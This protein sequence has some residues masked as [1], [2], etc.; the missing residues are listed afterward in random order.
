MKWMIDFKGRVIWFYGNS[1]SGKSTLADMLLG[2]LKE[3]YSNLDIEVLD[4]DNVREGLT[5]DLGFSIED[6]FEHIRRVSFVADL[7]SKHGVCVIASFITPLKAMRLFLEQKLGDRLILVH[8][9]S[10][11]ETCIKRDVKG[12]YKKALQG[13]IKDMTGLT[14]P[15]EFEYEFR[16][17]YII[18][19]TDDSIIEESFECL[20]KDLDDI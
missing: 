6:R 18:I 7:L 13:D 14:S 1:G 2:Y 12:L 11:I 8:V 17:P 15:A 9:D 4:G 19:D 16:E 20:L 10:S 3:N 5:K